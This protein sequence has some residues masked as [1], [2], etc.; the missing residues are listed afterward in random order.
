MMFDTSKMASFKNLYA[1][2]CI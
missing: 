2:L 1:I